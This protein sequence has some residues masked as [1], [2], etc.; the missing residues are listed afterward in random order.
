MISL[1]LSRAEQALFHQGLCSEHEVK[2]TV[3]VLNAE[4]K[5]LADVSGQL[6]DGQVNIDRIGGEVDRSLSISLFDPQRSMTFDTKSPYD[7]ALYL[8]R[9]IRVIYSVRTP[10][11]PKWVA[12]PVFTGPITKMSRSDDVINLECQGKEALAQTVA[13]ISK[14]YSK[15]WRH[16]SLIRDIMRFRA[17]ET[18]FSLPNWNTK[19]TSD[20]NIGRETNIWTAV[21]KLAGTN[22][23]FY[24]GRG[25]LTLREWPENASY[26]TFSTGTGGSI[27][28]Y[29]QISYDSDNMKNTIL[30]KGGIPKGSKKPI[31]YQIGAPVNHPV[32]STTLGRNGVRRILLDVIEDQRYTTREGAEKAAK[33]RLNMRL[34]QSIDVAFES[35]VIPHLEPGDRCQVKT[36]EFSTMILTNQMSIP[37]TGGT[38]SVGFLSRRTA[39]KVRSRR[40]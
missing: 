3:Q 15:G 2:I 13:W 18:K 26:F 14:S 27:T 22:H 4:H 6:L 17:G 33:S 10:L 40:K 31:E 25:Y 12:V 37:L 35:L 5:Y 23:L 19:T 30:V 32:S 39:K 1:G 11:L 36:P 21:K 9:M 7:T 34:M 38:M 24:D 16:T 28:S 29:P 8:D 20:F